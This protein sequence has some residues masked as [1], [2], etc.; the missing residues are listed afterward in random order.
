[1]TV[2][3]DAW[4]SLF[5]EPKEEINTEEINI[6][7]KTKPNIKKTTTSKPQ[8]IAKKTTK[9][10]QEIT[11]KTKR[12]TKTTTKGIKKETKSTNQIDLT[13]IEQLINK[14][15]EEIKSMIDKTSDFVEIKESFLLLYNSIKN[16][17]KN[18][19]NLKKLHDFF[20]N[21]K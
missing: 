15:T 6:V 21:N 13:K 7:K 4:D 1:M 2:E 3:K 20:T 16:I 5:D 10:K 8:Q 9:P 14:K 18:D 11:N 12:T 17:R 19:K